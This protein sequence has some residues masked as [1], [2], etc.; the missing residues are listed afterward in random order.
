MKMSDEEVKI[1]RKRSIAYPTGKASDDPI[2]K[3]FVISCPSSIPLSPVESS[4]FRIDRR[5]S[6]NLSLFHGKGA[7]LLVPLTT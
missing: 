5:E 3:S 2:H 1:P 6:P 4:P 7:F